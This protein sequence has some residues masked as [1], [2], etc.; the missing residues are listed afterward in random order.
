MSKTKDN[1]N[2]KVTFTSSLNPE[3]LQDFKSYCFKKNLKQNKVL[4]Q[5]IKELLEKE[6]DTDGNSN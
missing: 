2:I 4:E 3:L 6:G 5:L 1:D